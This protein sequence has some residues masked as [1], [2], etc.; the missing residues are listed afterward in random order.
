[1]LKGQS[2]HQSGTER[3]VQITPPEEPS[4]SLNRC[5]DG[6][7]FLYAKVKKSDNPH[8]TLRSLAKVRAQCLRSTACYNEVN[9]TPSR[10]NRTQALG[11]THPDRPRSARFHAIF[12]RIAPKRTL[13]KKTTPLIENEQGFSAI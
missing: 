9:R 7:C 11:S 2:F 5:H 8:A 13:L 12:F 4:A 1:M 6:F 10:K 3:H